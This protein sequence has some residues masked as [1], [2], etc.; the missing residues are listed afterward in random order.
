MQKCLACNIRKEGVNSCEM[1]VSVTVPVVELLLQSVSNH[2]ALFFIVLLPLVLLSLYLQYPSQWKLLGF[3]FLLWLG[4]FSSLLYTDSEL[5]WSTIKKSYNSIFF[6]PELQQPAASSSSVQPTS[7]PPLEPSPVVKGVV[8]GPDITPMFHMEPSKIEEQSGG[9]GEPREWKKC[10][11]LDRE[12]RDA[13]SENLLR[14]LTYSVQAD[15]FCSPPD[16][17]QLDLA[18]ELAKH[19]A[20]KNV[21]NFVGVNPDVIA[22][23][24]KQTAKEERE[25]SHKLLNKIYDEGYNGRYDWNM[26][27]EGLR[28]AGLDGIAVELVKML[29]CNSVP[30]DRQQEVKSYMLN[31]ITCKE[32]RF[33]L[34]EKVA[35]HWRDLA[36]AFNIKETSISPKA[37]VPERGA[38]EVLS[39]LYARGYNGQY[40]WQGV[41]DVLKDCH[42]PYTDNLWDTLN[43]AL[44][45]VC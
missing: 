16:M 10:K 19:S 7:A 21:A 26:Y 43:R 23:H 11:K 8:D 22:D 14:S 15:G 37:S 5:T 30:M 40:G 33:S 29:E 1:G 6:D 4:V 13:L 41:L 28:R 42:T 39:N 2:F 24:Y 35:D 34:E 45:C 27:V 18:K 12:D 31:S 44:N 38:S 20:W 17:Y 9:S 3:I 36:K 25:S 32:T